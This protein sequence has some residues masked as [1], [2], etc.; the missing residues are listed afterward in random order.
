MAALFPDPFL[1]VG[2]DENN[3]VQW[4]A[5]PRIQAF[6]IEHGLKD[7]AGLQTYFNRRVSAILARHGKQ[8]IGW[9]EILQPD[10]PKER[11]SDVPRPAALATRRGRVT[12]GCLSHGYYIDLM[13]PAAEH[14]F[15]DPLPAD[16]QPGA[17]R[18]A[19]HPRRRGDDVVGVGHAGEYRRANLAAHGGGR[20]TPVV[21]ARGP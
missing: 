20:G 17:R 12:A 10:L 6:I 2:G 15:N 14:Y 13:R 9:D 1:H 3:G 4:N 18:T 11:S 19:A 5:N 21:A 8:M 16:D 7:N